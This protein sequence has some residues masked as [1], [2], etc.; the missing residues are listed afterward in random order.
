[1]LVCIVYAAHRQEPPSWKTADVGHWSDLN[2][3][4]LR[5]YNLSTCYDECLS[6]WTTCYALTANWT[7]WVI[8]YHEGLL[9]G[10]I[11]VSAITVRS[12]QVRGSQAMLRKQRHQAAD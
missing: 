11:N 4:R 9:V 6:A 1:M 2:L 8:F 3:N 7:T 5:F 12:R 10:I